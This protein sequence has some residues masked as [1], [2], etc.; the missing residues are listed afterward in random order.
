[1]SDPQ[2]RVLGITP[3]TFNAVTIDGPEL[4]LATS[5]S[6]ERLLRV[7]RRRRHVANSA[8][9]PVLKKDRVEGCL[10]RIAG[11]LAAPVAKGRG[12]LLF[13]GDL[14]RTNPLEAVWDHKMGDL[15][16]VGEV[17]SL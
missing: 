15:V 11:R 6:A 13:L 2:N 3:L 7:K 10:C 17:I 4:D 16:A 1:M 14:P 8:E 12:L 9:L 5:K